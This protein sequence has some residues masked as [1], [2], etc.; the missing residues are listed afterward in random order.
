MTTSHSISATVQPLNNPGTNALFATNIISGK[1]AFSQSAIRKAAI[2]I[3]F[4]QV[5]FLMLGSD[6]NIFL[7]GIKWGHRRKPDTEVDL[8]EIKRR[9][10]NWICCNWAL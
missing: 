3:S 10:V 5:R 1:T 7:R 2:K 8:N 9:Q 6:E 4:Y